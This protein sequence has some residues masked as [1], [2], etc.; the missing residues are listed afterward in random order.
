MV[1]PDEPAAAGGAHA[2]HDGGTPR[3]GSA[4]RT[5][6]SGPAHGGLRI[7][8]RERDEVTRLLHDAFAQGRIT[9]EELDERLD[10]TLSARTAEDLRRVTADLP[11][12]WPGD[13]RTGGAPGGGPRTG[14]PW[15]A[16]FP[17][18][19]LPGFPGSPMGARPGPYGPLRPGGPQWAAAQGN[20]GQGGWGRGG[21]G[22]GMAPRWHDR[23]PHP[24]MFLIPV[25]AIVLLMAGPMWPPFLVLKLVFVALVVRAVLGM[26][27][28]RRHGPYSRH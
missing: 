26:T 18:A 3:A 22:R 12:A 8:D 15:H 24:A 6:P 21:W 10:A 13:A 25:A 19:G 17:S 23:R 7:G 28:R 27:H 5:P 2:G 1:S 4:G 11:G 20:W 9:R 14:S 16:G